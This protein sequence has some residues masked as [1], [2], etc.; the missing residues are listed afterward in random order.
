MK[1]QI[2]SI[3]ETLPKIKIMIK[4]CSLSVKTPLSG[5]HHNDF[6]HFAPYFPLGH[7]LLPTKTTSKILS[8]PIRTKFEKSVLFVAITVQFWD[9]QVLGSGTWEIQISLC[10]YISQVTRNVFLK[11]LTSATSRKSPKMSI[12]LAIFLLFTSLLKTS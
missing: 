2:D 12:K 3:L 5:M 1:D 8:K 4:A 9:H 11:I 6:W 7:P 10:S